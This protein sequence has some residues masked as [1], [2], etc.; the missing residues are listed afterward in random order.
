YQTTKEFLADLRNLRQRLEFEEVL[1]RSTDP[2]RVAVT[3]RQSHISR[4]RIAID[5]LAILPL[6]NNHADQ[7]MEYFSDGISESMIN[8]LS[9]LP[10]LRVMAWSTV[11]QY[12]GQQMDPRQAGRELDVRAVLTGRVMQSGDNLAIKVEMV[13]VADGSQ[14]WGG[15]CTCKPSDIL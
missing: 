13:D 7:S 11:S 8:S 15:G 6:Q 9:Q 3:N 5:S 10:D 12:K 14:L 4:S 2:G 1:E